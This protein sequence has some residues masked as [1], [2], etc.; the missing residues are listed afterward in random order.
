[1]AAVPDLAA[2]DRHHRRADDVLVI[3]EPDERFFAMVELSRSERFVMIGLTSKVT[4]EWY[5]VPADQPLAAPRVIA[6]RVHGV[7]YQAAHHG[8]R[9]L[10]LHNRD[11]EDWALAAT[12]VDAPGEW[13]TLIG[14]HLGT[15][16]GHVYEFADHLVISLRR[17]PDRPARGQ[18]GQP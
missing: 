6:P 11:A 15:R 3:E 2:R 4:A 16:L 18:P 8:D 5:V 7:K 12:P 9:F 17:G 13:T 10:I 14:H 1:M